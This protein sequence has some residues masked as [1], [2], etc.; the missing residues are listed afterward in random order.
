MGENLFKIVH[1]LI[2]NQT[3][4]R[5]LKY[6]DANPLDEEKEMVDG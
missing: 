3:L 1:K 4:C 2:H 6:Q 5:L